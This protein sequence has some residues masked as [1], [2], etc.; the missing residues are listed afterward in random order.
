[1]ETSLE[2]IKSDL[3]K[4]GDVIRIP[5]LL[6]RPFPNQPR[7]Y[8]DQTKL[9]ALANSIRELGQ[10]VPI[11]V[12]E[13]KSGNGSSCSYE[14]ID[15]QRR[16]HACTIA[17]VEM[18]T[19]IVIPVKDEEEQFTIS[20]T[21]NLGRVGHDPIETVLA[22]KRFRDN[23]KSVSWIA[24]VFT[25]SEVSIYQYLKLLRLD[26]EVFNMM[27]PEIPEDER[28]IFSTAVLLSD[29]PL[30]IQK[31]T[32]VTVVGKKLVKAKNMIRA[33]AREL[34]IKVGD[35]KRSPND[36]YNVLR[37]LIKR[38]K[39]ELDVIL[40][41]PQVSFD[42]MFQFRKDSDHSSLVDDLSSTIESMDLL[43]SVVR[44]ARKK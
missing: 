20:V 2:P 34:G 10:L 41:M 29:L 39:R 9:V 8:F 14:L 21:A 26:P 23:G 13:L 12:R 16:W 5:R 42:R 37:S 27:S 25:L 17:D 6:I 40:S 35:P 18:M 43:L 3:E 22:I 36:D 32:A 30:E 7:K 19:A 31:S 24:S 33:Q 38:L 1:M 11:F 15:G 28:L 4:V 44:K